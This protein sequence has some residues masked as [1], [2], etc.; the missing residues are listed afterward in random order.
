MVGGLT[1][2][3]E[4]HTRSRQYAAHGARPAA[5]AAT[6]WVRSHLPLSSASRPPVL[7]CGAMCC[8][9]IGS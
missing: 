4:R 9:V 3:G 5:H 2:G 8:F 7:H 1:R 6:R